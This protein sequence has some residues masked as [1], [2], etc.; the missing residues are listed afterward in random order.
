[1]RQV[2]KAKTKISFIWP[3]YFDKFVAADATKTAMK[4]PD[5]FQFF[6]LFLAFLESE[7]YGAAANGPRQQLTLADRLALH[8][9]EASFIH[10]LK[11]HAE[12]VEAYRWH[13]ISSRR[14]ENVF[15]QL[16]NGGLGNDA[17]MIQFDFK[18]NVRYPMRSL[19]LLRVA[20]KLF[21]SP[22][23]SLSWFIL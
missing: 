7:N 13:Q 6:S 5:R 4:D 14:Q 17:V 9:T 15:M 2:E 10:E 1:M 3:V 18:E 20:L 23:A 8:R 21:L 11:S 22:V 12:L 16:R 19:A